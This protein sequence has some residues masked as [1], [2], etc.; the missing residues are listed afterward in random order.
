MEITPF[1]TVEDLED[2]WR[3]LNEDEKARA[4]TQ[5]ID[6]TAYMTELMNQ[7][8]VPINV[9]DVQQS[10]VLKLVCCAVTRRSLSQIFSSDG[11]SPATGVEDASSSTITAG[12]FS[13]TYKY[14]NPTGS[15]YL[16]PDEKK[17]LG[18]G[19]MR[20]SSVAPYSWRIDHV[21]G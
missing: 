12:V 1:A 21:E 15:I 10:Q 2:R 6:V 16:R 14:A 19:R 18:I 11:S 9:K 13:Q 7:S 17:L 20:V 8:K 3:P 5:L 4:E